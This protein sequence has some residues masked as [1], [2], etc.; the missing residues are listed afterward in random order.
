[1]RDKDGRPLS[2]DGKRGEDERDNRKEPLSRDGKRGE[3]KRN[4]RRMPEYIRKGVG[5]DGR[6]PGSENGRDPYN[7]TGKDPSD[8]TPEERQDYR[9][10]QMEKGRDDVLFPNGNP[11]PIDRL[12]INGQIQDTDERRHAYVDASKDVLR[13]GRRYQAERDKKIEAIREESKQA[14]R[15]AMEDNKDKPLFDRLHAVSDATKDY[16]Q[17]MADTNEYY[18]DLADKRIYEYGQDLG[19]ADKQS[20]QDRE[21]QRANYFKNIYG[22]DFYEQDSDMKQPGNER[23]DPARRQAGSSF[24]NAMRNQESNMQ[25]DVDNKGMR[26]HDRDGVSTDIER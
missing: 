4:D 2:E 11:T 20:F 25:R 18:E 16:R 19:E 22:D 12:I 10:R 21:N 8:M 15:K 13:D 23:R 1:M 3:A 5:F 6:V 7:P 24:Q 26:G 17:E 14:A 9:K